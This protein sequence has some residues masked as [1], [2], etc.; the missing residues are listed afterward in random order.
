[1]V[2]LW[3]AGYAHAEVRGLTVDELLEEDS[4]VH[5]LD[6]AHEVEGAGVDGA[7]MIERIGV[8]LVVS[9]QRQQV[10]DAKIVD[11]DER[12]LGLLAREAVAEQVRD[13]VDP[14][15]VLGGGAQAD[16]AGPLALDVPADGA[17]RHLLVVDL[18][19]VP[20]HVD[21]RRLE[22]EQLLDDLEDA[23]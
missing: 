16:R 23:L 7:A 18:G 19:R 20:G 1:E 5:V 8:A 3:V 10:L 11:I 12:V 13:G 21:E 6:L 22:G 2:L 17:V 9:A 4:A 15:A 14:V